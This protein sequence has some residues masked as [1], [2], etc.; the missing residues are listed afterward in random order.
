VDDR[1]LPEALLAAIPLAAVSSHFY[2][3]L[4]YPRSA[5]LAPRAATRGHSNSNFDAH[6]SS[7]SAA[8]TA[9]KIRSRDATMS[10]SPGSCRRRS[11]TRRK[12]NHNRVRQQVL[13]FG[14]LQL[15]V[16]DYLH[17]VKIEMYNRLPR[18]APGPAPKN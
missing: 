17:Y 13:L 12:I 1:I 16:S 11:P 3:V 7:A 4:F 15:T 2:I 14:E 5:L 9:L 6:P 8:V 18:A 10:K